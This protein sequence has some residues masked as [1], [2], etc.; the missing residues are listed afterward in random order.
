MEKIEL[1]KKIYFELENR[2]NKAYE[3]AKRNF[4]IQSRMKSIN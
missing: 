1:A 2:K 3:I 4:E